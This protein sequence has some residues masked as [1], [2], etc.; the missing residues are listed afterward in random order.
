MGKIAWCVT[1]GGHLLK[2]CVALLERADNLE[3]YPTPAGLEIMDMYKLKP[4]V[5]TVTDPTASTVTCRGF[6][7]GEYDLLVVAP[8]TSNGVAK[9]VCGISDSMVTTLFAQCG[10]SRVPIIVLP[11]DVEENVDSMGLTKPIKVYPRPIDLKN[12]EELAKFEGVTVVKTIQELENS[13]G[14]YTNL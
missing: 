9:F 1:G 11:T 5:K 13:I 12:I 3:L 14:P 2:E 7:T 8:A 10:K 6:A 4:S